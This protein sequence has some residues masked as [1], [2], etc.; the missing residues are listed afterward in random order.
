[1]AKRGTAAIASREEKAKIKSVTCIGE[2]NFVKRVSTLDKIEKENIKNN[3]AVP[4]IF[5][6]IRP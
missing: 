6:A 5:S 4:A 1:M 2:C 3:R